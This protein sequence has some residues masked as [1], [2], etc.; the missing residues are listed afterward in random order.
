[1]VMNQY[2]YIQD[3]NSFAQV[4]TKRLQFLPDTR[5][6]LVDG[7][8]GGKTFN[9]YHSSVGWWSGA[10]IVH[11]VSHEHNDVLGQAG[12]NITSR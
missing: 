6:S 7:V 5:Y 2:R 8:Q 4:T 10:V 12:T 1:M 9:I 3:K 11:C